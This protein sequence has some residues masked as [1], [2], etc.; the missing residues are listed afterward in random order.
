[1]LNKL[2]AAARSL[3]IGPGDSVVCALSGGADS[4]AMTFGFYLLREQLGIA[5]EAAHFDHNLRGEESREDARFAEEFCQG[6][7]IRLHMG[8]APVTPGKKGLEAAAREARY[9]FLLSLPGKILTAHTADDNAETVLMHLLRGT[10][11]RG[12]GGIAPQNG[13][14]LRPMLDITRA[15]V[16][17][18]LTEYALPHREDSSNRGDDFLRNRLRHGVMPLLRRE[19]PSLAENVSAMAL[20]L[21]RDEKYIQSQL[22]AGMP[23][24]G[25]LRAMDPALQS[26]C[27]ERFLRQCGVKEPQQC[28]LE[29]V[30]GL[31][32]SDKPSARGNF[33]GG[34]TIARNYDRLEKQET[35]RTVEEG[36]LEGTM[37]LPQAGLR[38]RVVPA[39]E[40]LE[41]PEAFTVRPRGSI[42]VRSRREGDAIRTWGGAK[43]VKK[44]FID[45]KIPACQRPAMPVLEDDEGILGVYPIGPDLD[46]LAKE[47]PA[48]T[49]IFEKLSH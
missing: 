22:P 9:A 12:L 27:L 7:G 30:R 39:E 47:L 17:A 5:L 2:A 18:F 40:I 29:L 49:I 37:E 23:G 36:L 38:I 15:E 14:V 10:G 21:R 32:Y 45:R 35:P 11:L 34:I 1:M 44:L 31:V 24:V 41:K 3:G 33:P 46:R 25:E 4:V 13:R 26:R 20:R 19:N 8:S 48:V 43:S 28:H 6:Y 16:E 42:R